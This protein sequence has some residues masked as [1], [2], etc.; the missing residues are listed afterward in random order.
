MFSCCNKHP[1]IFQELNI[2]RTYLLFT[3]KSMSSSHN[4]PLWIFQVS[5]RLSTTWSL[6]LRRLPPVAVP[7]PLHWAGIWEKRQRR[8]FLT[9]KCLGLEMTLITSTPFLWGTTWPD[10]YVTG[11]G[12]VVPGWAS[13]AQ[14]QLYTMEG[15]TGLCGGQLTVSFK[16]GHKV[17]LLRF[18]LPC[19]VRLFLCPCLM[20]GCFHGCQE[21][22]SKNVTADIHF[23]AVFVRQLT[24]SQLENSLLMSTSFPGT[25]T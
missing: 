21:L 11:L 18:S 7:S 12:N 13:A 5:G 16:G 6:G 3:Y 22:L 24:V 10:L 4:H 25:R 19:S 2:T 15:A 23:L 8:R 14:R 20:N 1:S 17:W 9:F